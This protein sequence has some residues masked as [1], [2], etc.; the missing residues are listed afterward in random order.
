MGRFSSLMIFFAG[1]GLASCRVQLSCDSFLRRIPSFS[2][3]FEHCACRFGNWSDDVVPLANE[4]A[5]RVPLTECESG[6]KI[7]TGVRI[8]HPIGYDNITCGENGEG[9]EACT[10]NLDEVFTCVMDCQYDM[11]VTAVFDGASEAIPVPQNQCSS[12]YAI[13]GRR[14]LQAIG[15]YQCVGTRCRECDDEWEQIHMC[16]YLQLCS[17]H[18]L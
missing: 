4:I 7:A 14:R 17:L 10:D 8:Q 6:L 18:N 9:C 5:V 16:K 1:F 12:G 11:N 3:F 13:P 15:G 2:I